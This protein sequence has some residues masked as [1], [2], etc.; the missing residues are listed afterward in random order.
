[1]VYRRGLIAAVLLVM[2]LGSIAMADAPP[3]FKTGRVTVDGLTVTA[4][5]GQG[6]YPTADFVDVKVTVTN[7]GDRPQHFRSPNGCRQLVWAQRISPTGVKEGFRQHGISFC[8]ASFSTHVLAPGASEEANLYL[9]SSLQTGEGLYT[10]EVQ[11][12][13][14][15]PIVVQVL[16]RVGDFTDIAQYPSADLVRKAA[17]LGLIIG[18]P[19]G[20]FRPDHPVTYAEFIKLLVQTV[21]LEPGEPGAHW[22]DPWFTAAKGHGWI[23]ESQQPEDRPVDWDE[24]LRLLE[25]AGGAGTARGPGLFVSRADAAAMMVKLHESKT[26]P[27]Q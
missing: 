4:T 5:M 17:R 21:G 14:V 27:G 8:T 19:D 15:N 12:G 24:A 25:K 6:L 13:T 3:S 7:T 11:T 9:D 26:T 22:S 10:V 23:P 1:M 20:T 18:Y 16:Y 2:L